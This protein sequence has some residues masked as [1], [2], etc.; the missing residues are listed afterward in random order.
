[1][2]TAM[3]KSVFRQFMYVSFFE[4]KVQKGDECSSS[5]ELAYAS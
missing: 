4:S 2:A 5:V 3:S 1:M